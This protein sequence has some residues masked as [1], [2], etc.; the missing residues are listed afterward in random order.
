MTVTAETA[1]VIMMTFI[2]SHSHQYAVY[3][4]N[5]IHLQGKYNLIKKRIRNVTH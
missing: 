3:T 4:P 5:K 2:S 1:T